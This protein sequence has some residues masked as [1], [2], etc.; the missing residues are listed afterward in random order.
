MA[1]KKSAKAAPESAAPSQPQAPPDVKSFQAFE[2]MT[3]MR[4]QLA[5]H[6]TNPRSID[7][8]AFK[9]LKDYLKKNKLLNALVVNRRS[10]AN[11]FPEAEEGRLVIIGGHQR[12]RAMD[13]LAGF[14]PSAPT[15]EHDYQVPIDVVSV[16]PGREKEILVALNNQSLQ[17]TY[18][19]D[20]LADLLTDPAVDPFATG[21]DRAELGTLLDAGVLEQIMGAPVAAQAA[22]EAPIVDALNEI[23]E[24]S[25]AAQRPQPQADTG[26]P[27]VI[28][29]P[30]AGQPISA[31][32]GQQVAE[33][34]DPNSVEA[35][36]QR[37]QDYR[38]GVNSEQNQAGFFMVLVADRD[39]DITKF[40]SHLGLPPDQT[41]Y[42]LRAF[43]ERIGYRFDFGDAAEPAE[44]EREQVDESPA[45][46]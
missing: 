29:Q 21:F 12:T 5:T 46:G 42:P 30:A 13:S 40:T 1:K 36:K 28:P 16:G 27:A 26:S 8:H 11:G 19:L 43:L 20:M 25:K 4:S 37:R 7:Q 6:E 3:A 35:M 32:T 24:V 15:P 9:K 41:Y 18:D 23:A 31:T 34:L 2:R 10:S 22:A 33:R 39:E 14:D 17:G 38:E 45:D 44:G